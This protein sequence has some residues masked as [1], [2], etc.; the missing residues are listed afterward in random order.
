MSIVFGLVL[1]FALPQHFTEDILTDKLARLT[2][3]IISAGYDARFREEITVVLIDQNSL[4]PHT[5]PLTYDY[6]SGLLRK[7]ADRSPKAIFLDV[8]LVHENDKTFESLKKAIADLSKGTKNRGPIKIFLAAIRNG[9]S[10]KISRQVD[11]LKEPTEVAVEYEP[12][13][14]DRLAWTYPLIYREQGSSTE[15]TDRKVEH[16]ATSAAGPAKLTG[17][18]AEHTQGRESKKALSAAYAIYQALYPV[19][20]NSAEHDE[21]LPSTVA[22]TWGLPPDAKGP[23]NWVHEPSEEEQKKIK[24]ERGHISMGLRRLVY[25]IWFGEL[26]G[27]KEW[28]GK[29][30][31]TDTRYCSSMGV[32]D[33]GLL[34]W[35]AEARVMFPSIGLPLCAYHRTVIAG[36]MDNLDD[37]ERTDAF[38]N[39]VVMIGTALDDGGDTV[40]SPLHD[41]LPGVYL[42]AM[43]LD[44]LLAWNGRYVEDREPALGL[45]DGKWRL[46]GVALI[47][48]LGVFAQRY[49]KDRFKCPI[50]PGL[51]RK[52]R[53]A[54]KRSTPS[55]KKSRSVM[56]VPGTAIRP[57]QALTTGR[58]RPLRA[59]ATQRHHEAG[60]PSIGRRIR[61]VVGWKLLTLCVAIFLTLGLLLLG[62]WIFHESYLAVAHVVSCTMAVEWLEWGEK[63]VNF[64]TGHEEAES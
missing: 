3:P 59:R 45:S 21:E 37:D 10:L 40:V 30:D 6:Y 7:I 47:G 8:V 54:T 62:Q 19:Q 12:S 23:K 61:T 56:V 11:E 49:F 2:A 64:L 48:M 13:S 46:E 26:G 43:A 5:W 25:W 42:H 15:E 4:F 9:A 52:V 63:F 16:A 51:K 50:G 22:L 34:L 58:E 38:S 60:T 28:P 44:N 24:E 32:T 53:E 57:T 17:A 27:P 18:D 14:I 31:G 33:T 36:E 20:A 1:A 35:R 29:L 41:R 55:Q 39:R